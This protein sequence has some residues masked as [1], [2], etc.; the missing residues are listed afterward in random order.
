MVWLR[1]HQLNHYALATLS[2]SLFKITE[3]WTVPDLQNHDVHFDRSQV[4]LVHFAV[5]GALHSGMR[6]F[7]RLSPSS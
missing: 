5:G 7:N 4:V 6:T 2:V 3:C 1:A